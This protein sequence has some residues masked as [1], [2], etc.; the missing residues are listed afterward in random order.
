M[1]NIE[2]ERNERHGWLRL[3]LVL[4]ALALLILWRVGS[5]AEMPAANEPTLRSGSDAARS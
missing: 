4:A 5:E 1:A 2:P 3:V